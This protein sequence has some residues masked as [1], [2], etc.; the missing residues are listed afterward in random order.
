M[1]QHE[2]HFKDKC[3]LLYA[4]F[5]TKNDQFNMYL[6]MLLQIAITDQY[7]KDRVTT[8]SDLSIKH[9]VRIF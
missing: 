9:F 2:G 7:C 5:V 4:S 8:P 1:L 3:K 6:L